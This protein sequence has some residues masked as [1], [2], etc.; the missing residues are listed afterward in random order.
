M[1]QRADAHGR[2]LSIIGDSH[3]VLLVEGV[4]QSRRVVSVDP[5]TTLLYL[6]PRLMHSVGRDGFPSWV[7][8][9]VR[10]WR[11]SVLA[12]G[13]RTVALLLGE[14]DLRCHLAKPGR[15]DQETLERLAESYLVQARSLA[16]QLGPDGRVVVCSPNPPSTTYESDEAFPVVGSADERAAI[17]DRL[18]R[19]LAGGIQAANDKRLRFLDVRPLVAG[20]NGHLREEFTFDGCHLNAAGAALVR[21]KLAELTA[22]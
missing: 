11:R 12:R 18:C 17:L 5:T 21:A 1:G 2:S 3:A 6:G 4:M 15:S 14:I 8:C 10:S 19:S 22:A 13:R 20:P 7:L 9:L 16:D